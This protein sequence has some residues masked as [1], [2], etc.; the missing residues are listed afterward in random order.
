MT[1]VTVDYED[2]ET[3]IFATGAIKKIE[4]AI[5][6]VK[7]DPFVQP[8][9]NFGPAHDRL[10]SA[11]RNAKRAEANDTVV[12]FDEPLTR[13]E[14]NALRYV[15]LASQGLDKKGK[16][17]PGPNVFTISPADK[18]GRPSMS[19]YDR[20]TAKGCLEVG[21]WVEGI[22]WTG[23]PAVS[24]VPSPNPRGYAARLTSR[25]REKLAALKPKSAPSS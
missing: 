18:D 15:A 3:I 16:S 25:G 20:L 19:V 1:I 12:K 11:M 24:V 17:L 2:L 4:D 14:E 6:A 22:V 8:H 5:S 7:R 10:A 21:T 9:L 13:E 23:A